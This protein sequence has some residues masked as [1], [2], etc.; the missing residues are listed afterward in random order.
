MPPSDIH[1]QLVK[2][3]TDAHSIEEQ[4][5]TQMRRAPDIAGEGRLAEAF[6]EHFT[7]TERHERLVRERLEALGE[8]TSTLKDLAGKAGGGGVGVLSRVNP[9]TPRKIA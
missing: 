4:A 5:L 1:E 2:H 8:D 3:L 9:G 7:E 6:R